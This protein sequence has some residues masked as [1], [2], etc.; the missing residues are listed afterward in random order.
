LPEGVQEE[1]AD[2]ELERRRKVLGNGKSRERGGVAE[3]RVSGLTM[4]VLVTRRKRGYSFQ[5]LARWFM[6][7]LRKEMGPGTTMAV[8]MR[9][10]TMKMTKTMD[11][12]LRFSP[13]KDVSVYWVLSSAAASMWMC[14]SGGIAPAGV[15]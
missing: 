3:G 2:D 7:F 11:H 6:N 10:S 15:V 14:C 9:I 1:A 5:S 8:H 4:T 13:R 12:W